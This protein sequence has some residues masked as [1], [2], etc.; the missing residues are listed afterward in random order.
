M[1]IHKEMVW[2]K[3]ANPKKDGEYLLAQFLPDG[4]N[5]SIMNVEYTVAYGWNTGHSYQGAGFG[6]T[7]RNGA[8]MWAELPFSF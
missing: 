6:Q 4:T 1:K 5:Y 7:P 3:G 2:N 8:Y